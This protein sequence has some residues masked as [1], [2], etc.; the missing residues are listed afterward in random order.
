MHVTHGPRGRYAQGPPLRYAITRA[1]LIPLK[2]KA[3]PNNPRPHGC[4]LRPPG[5]GITRRRHP[6]PGSACIGCCRMSGTRM[7]PRQSRRAAKLARA[8]QDRRAALRF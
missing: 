5:N 4:D 7:H 2:G 6:D 1:D 3:S 8:A